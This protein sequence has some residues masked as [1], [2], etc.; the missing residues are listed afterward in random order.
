MVATGFLSPLEQYVGIGTYSKHHELPEGSH[1]NDEFYIRNMIPWADSTSDRS[2]CLPFLP[3]VHRRWWDKIY[4]FAGK[5]TGTLAKRSHD[6][7]FHC[8]ASGTSTGPTSS[9]VW[10][11]PKNA[12]SCPELDKVMGEIPIMV[13]SWVT[14]RCWGTSRLATTKPY[15]TGSDSVASSSNGPPSHALNML[16]L[17]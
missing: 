11:R 16:N 7:R 2:P 13:K 17:R 14:N 5:S 6:C 15:V 3:W 1:R 12:F 4:C 8:V 9:T 10:K